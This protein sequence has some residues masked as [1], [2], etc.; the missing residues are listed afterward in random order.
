[1][2][3]GCQGGHKKREVAQIHFLLGKF[4][5]S[6]LG[7]GKELQYIAKTKKMGKN[8]E[9]KSTVLLLSHHRTSKETLERPTNR[10]HSHAEKPAI[11]SLL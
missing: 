9:H 1:M 3:K 6:Y 10:K 4:K 11:G 2:F 8:R 5:L 7:T